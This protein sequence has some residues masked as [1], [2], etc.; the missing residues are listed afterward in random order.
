MFYNFKY[1]MS[2]RG[3]RIINHHNEF[4]FNFR[5]SALYIVLITHSDVGARVA[6]I[7]FRVSMRERYFW[8]N[9]YIN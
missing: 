1:K 4:N 2:E 9:V 8:S 6:R 7:G 5:F 3:E